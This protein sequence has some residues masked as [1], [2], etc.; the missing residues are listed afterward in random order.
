MIRVRG[1]CA[2]LSPENIVRHIFECRRTQILG[3]R[4]LTELLNVLSEN[5]F[6]PLSIFDTIVQVT[7]T[8]K[9]IRTGINA[10][11]ELGRTLI[12]VKHSPERINVLELHSLPNLVGNDREE[13]MLYENSLKLLRTRQRPVILVKSVDYLY[14]FHASLNF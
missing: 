1:K 6:V 2:V 9:R 11:H 3:E 14:A 5:S 7:T 13:W 10:I 8:S 4:N 12:K